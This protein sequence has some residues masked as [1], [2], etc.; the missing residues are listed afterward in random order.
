LDLIIVI[1]F[2]VIY[3]LYTLR[4]KR[5]VAQSEAYYKSLFENQAQVVVIEE[6]DT[7][8]SLV[9]K[10]FEELSG[11]SKA[12]V[13][14]KMKTADFLPSDE[15]EKVLGYHKARVDKS[16]PP[17]PNLYETQF[18]TK[19]GKI[20]YIQVYANLI[21]GTK[22]TVA[23]INDI[24]QMK[25]AQIELE[26]ARKRLQRA[27]ELNL[28]AL[29]TALESR[30]HGTEYHC[31][32][33]ACYAILLARK[34]GVDERHIESIRCGALLH[35][36]GKIGIGDSLLLKPGKLTPE[37]REKIKKHPLIGADILRGIDYFARAVEVVLY[38][39]ERWDGSGYPMGLSGDKIPLS[40]RIFCC[41]GCL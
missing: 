11:Y 26:K 18:L 10:K 12:E 6:E 15:R 23:V 40:T 8:F 29:T 38:H 28:R 36:I 9:N 22:K 7:T 14:G 17:P 32:R 2:L 19:D 31:E 33:V 34:M 37:E 21:P 39:H 16:L 35:D 24:T 13:E 27:Y 5:K 1:I 30:E 25:K 20:K 4:I 41:G 3:L